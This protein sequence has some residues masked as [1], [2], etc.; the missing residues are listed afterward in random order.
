MDFKEYLSRIE[1]AKN[2][3][4]SEQHLME[5][6]FPPDCE[7]SA[8]GIA[9]AFEIIHA[10]SRND[11]PQLV[12]LYGGNLSAMCRLFNIPLRTAQA[13]AAGERDPSP[14]LMCLIG[15]ALISLCEKDEERSVM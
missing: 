10:V 6:G 2:Y 11:F 13:W 1:D 3:P 14:Y 7:F 9:K 15:F 12:E 4:T 8:H 5:Y